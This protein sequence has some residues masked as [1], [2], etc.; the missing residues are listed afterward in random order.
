ME[1]AAFRPANAAP[2]KQKDRLMGALLTRGKAIRRT[3]HTRVMAGLLKIAAAF[4]PFKSIFALGF[5]AFTRVEQVVEYQC[6]LAG[7]PLKVRF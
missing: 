6:N 3:A 4:T 1:V 5:S 7:P 2:K